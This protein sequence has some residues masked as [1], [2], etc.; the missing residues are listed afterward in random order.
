MIST[1]PCTQA[2]KVGD[3]YGI[4]NALDPKSKQNISPE[5]R[6][7]CQLFFKLHKSTYSSRLDA[8]EDFLPGFE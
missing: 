5:L 4:I 3:I 6:P 2:W 7:C 8:K 1:S